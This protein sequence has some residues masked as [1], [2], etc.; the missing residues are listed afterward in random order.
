MQIEIYKTDKEY[1]WRIKARN[2]R[3]V[4]A[5]SEAFKRRAG[6]V[7]NLAITFDYFNTIAALSALVKLTL[8][9]DVRITRPR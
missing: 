2:G 5:S 9:E 7:R 8:P 6:A 1:R 3:I 4:A